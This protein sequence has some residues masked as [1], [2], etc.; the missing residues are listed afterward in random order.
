MGQLFLAGSFDTPNN[1][2]IYDLAGDGTLTP[3]S[4]HNLAGGGTA[5]NCGAMSPDGADVYLGSTTKVYKYNAALDTLDTSWA[6]SGIFTTSGNPTDIAVDSSGNVAISTNSAGP[7]IYLLDSD[8]V[9]SWAIDKSGGAGAFRCAF[10]VSGEILGAFING[11]T[12]TGFRLAFADGAEQASYGTFKSGA[13]FGNALISDGTD[14]FFYIIA[15]TSTLSGSVAKVPANGVGVTWNSGNWPSAMQ[16]QLLLHSGGRLYTCGDGDGGTIGSITEWNPTT[17]AII[18]DYEG[19][20]IA[21]NMFEDIGTGFIIVA[22]NV[23]VGDDAET[24]NVRVFDTSLVLKDS[25]SI[26]T[27][28]TSVF[29]PAVTAPTITSEPIGEVLANG[30]ALSLTVVSGGTPTL[31]YQ[32][33]LGGVNI[34]GATSATYAV[35]SVTGV[36][37]GIYTCVVTNAQGTDTTSNIEIAVRAAVTSQSGNTTE[38]VGNSATIQ[39]LGNGGPS[40]AFQWKLDGVPLVGE[41]STDYVMNPIVLADA[42]TYINTLSISPS[43]T[44]IQWDSYAVNDGVES[45]AVAEWS[46]QLFLAATDLIVTSIRLKLGRDSSGDVDNIIVSIQGIDGS[47]KPDGTDLGSGTIAMSTLDVATESIE[48]ITMDTPFAINAGTKYNIVVKKDANSGGRLGVDTAGG[49]TN[50]L[51]DTSDSGATWADGGESAWFEVWGYLDGDPDTDSAP[52]LMTV[53][54]LSDVPQV[55]FDLSIDLDRES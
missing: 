32:W 24:A 35:G 31:T 49:Y 6:T 42:G 51:W 18:N 52:I 7:N 8:G 12:N 26:G 50:I 17:G 37:A 36:D 16:R 25:V 3:T 48:S 40:L 19:G 27:N 29:T 54:P 20:A 1:A 43:T 23:G 46:G 34:S 41:T 30:S 28:I 33:K 2:Y 9:Q 4:T 13:N 55:M 10:A 47:E 39:V 45:V 22:G 21:L 53:L 44:P 14:V 11:T 38:R 15:R 5:I